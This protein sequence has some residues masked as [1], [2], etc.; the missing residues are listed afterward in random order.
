[1]A[2]CSPW[3]GER[4][5]VPGLGLEL[6]PVPAGSFQMGSDRGKVDSRPVHTVRITRDFWL[7]RTEVTQ[8]QYEAL[9]GANPSEFRGPDLPVEGV[10][11]EDAAGYCRRLTKREQAAG[12]LPDGLEYRL[13]TEAEWEYAA[14]G[15]PLSQGHA[16]AGSGVWRWW[17]GLPRT[18][19]TPRIRLGRRWPTG[20][21]CTT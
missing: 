9:A 1:V 7:G 3:P 17:P 8:R 6:V 13:P 14:R 5:T 12:R 2:A 11:W 15:G 4:W 10:N 19:P 21:G 18:A 16:Y 20:L